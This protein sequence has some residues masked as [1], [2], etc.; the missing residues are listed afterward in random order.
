MINT[1]KIN[2]NKKNIKQV[3]RTGV[4]GVIEIPAFLHARRIQK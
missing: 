3:G 1:N 4:C 2:R